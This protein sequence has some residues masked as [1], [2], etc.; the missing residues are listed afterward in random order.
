MCRVKYTV[1][2]SLGFLVDGEKEVYTNPGSGGEYFFYVTPTEVNEY[3]GEIVF[4]GTEMININNPDY[5][6]G[7]FQIS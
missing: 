3:S 6:S 2:S 4:T 1:S 7:S 5:D